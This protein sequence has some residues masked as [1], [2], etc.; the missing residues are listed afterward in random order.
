MGEITDS[1][2]LGPFILWPWLST[3]H[4]RKWKIDNGSALLPYLEFTVVGFST[5]LHK[6]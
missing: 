2:Q 3:V 6:Y 5:F 1:F 4:H